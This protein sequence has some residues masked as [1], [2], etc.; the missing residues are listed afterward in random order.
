MAQK[1]SDVRADHIEFSFW[2]IFGSDGSMRFARGKPHIERHERAM[3]LSA[4]L[5][6][7]L[8]RTPELSGV[9]RIADDGGKP[10]DID[11][12]TAS[13]ALEAALGI[14][15]DLRVKGPDE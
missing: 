3:K 10:F 7:T 9:I 8:F 13:A 14:D 11:V 4:T 15:I 12:Q 5:P 1:Y 6:K 2:L